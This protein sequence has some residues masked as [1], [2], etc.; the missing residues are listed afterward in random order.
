MKADASSTPD[1]VEY[2][3]VEIVVEVT[4]HVKC[5][6]Y[7]KIRCPSATEG[8]QVHARVGLGGP[9]CDGCG[10]DAT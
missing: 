2:A 7:G 10:H 5:W 8:V 4:L 9:E 6:V 1:A 3:V